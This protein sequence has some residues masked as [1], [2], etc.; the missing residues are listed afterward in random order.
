MAADEVA[1]VAPAP[2][3]KPHPE[4]ASRVWVIGATRPVTVPQ[5][6]MPAG[7]VARGDATGVRELPPCQVA[8]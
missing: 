2:R 6:S 3:L 5:G 1:F 8:W 4:A 7:T